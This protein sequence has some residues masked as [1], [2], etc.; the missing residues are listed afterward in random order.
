MKL[1]REI[2]HSQVVAKTLAEATGPIPYECILAGI[3]QNKKS[4][5]Q[6][7]IYEVFV[8]ANLIWFF[9]SGRTN[10]G[11]QLDGL[12]NID[13]NATTT[14][15]VEMVREL[16]ADDLVKLSNELLFLIK[17]GQATNPYITNGINAM[18]PN[19][20]VKYALQKQD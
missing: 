10:V 20:W 17:V 11:Q 1:H 9:S 2:M 16:S 6:L 7:D 12:V 5:E 18:T 15:A 19:E 8:V 14:E 4:G 3:A 13:S